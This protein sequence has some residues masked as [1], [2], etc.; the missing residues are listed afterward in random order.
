MCLTL[1]GLHAVI[2]WQDRSVKANLAF[3]FLAVSVALFTWCC[4]LMMN[5][6]TTDA[7]AWALWLSNVTV[8]LMI[9]GVTRFVS[10][11]FRT[12]R[13]WL[14]RAAWGL[15]LIALGA[16]VVRAPKSDF[17]SISAVRSVS[18]LGDQVSVATGTVSF[19]YWAGQISLVLLLAFVADACW[20][21]WR[22]G[23]RDEKR[24][25]LLIGAPTALFVLLGTASA[26]LIFGGLVEWPHLEFLPSL[27]VLLAMGYQLTADVLRAARLARDL[28]KSE[29]ALH[30]SNHRMTMAADA[31]RLGMWIWD[32]QGGPDDE[33]WLTP[34][35]RE[36]LGFAPDAQVSYEQFLEQLH[37]DD[38]ERVEAE[39]RRVVDTASS[40][41]MEYRIAV[42]GGALRWVAAHMRVDRNRSGQAVRLLGICI[43][44]TEQRT[45]ELA[46]RELSGKLI[47]AQ[48][49]ERR[50]IARDLHD[51]LSQ[52]LSVLSVDLHLLSRGQP[53]RHTTMSELASRVQEL[54]SEV[55]KVAYQL[56]PAKLDQL[57]L[58]IAARSW[59][60]DVTKQNGVHVDF[61]ASN[62]PPDLPPELAL[63]LYRIIQE[64]LRN[65]VRHSQAK[66]ARVEVSAVG[67]EIRLV[68]TDSGNGF[69]VETAATASGL[70]L[71]GMRERAYLLG[72][73][74]AVQSRPGAGTQ[75]DV[76]IP[77]LG[78]A[79][80]GAG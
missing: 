59:C 2:W 33:L 32:L 44:V 42:A 15:R 31:A 25:A 19:W 54:S 51:D 77:F 70:G 50:R 65:V 52:R 30:E 3:S 71:V 64:S 46:A 69:N 36:I 7:F 11:Y 18:F 24:R 10:A 79:A 76:A 23:D 55:H 49:D 67:D 29:A 26:A 40:H 66:T 8:F 48:E 58:E 80:A 41:E 14:G 75:V 34:K 21:L 60:R 73:R 16:H 57:G 37:P 1:A 27:G 45:T 53:E 6:Q 5:A 62:V 74:I 78:R 35:C 20:T 38:R 68:V 17:D 4:L 9:V 61:V 13:P 47:N 12:A 39:T 56:H 63:C 43:D 72:G 22:I 28:Q